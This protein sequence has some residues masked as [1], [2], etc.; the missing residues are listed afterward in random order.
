ML[1]LSFETARKVDAPE[2]QLTEQAK[3][4]TVSLSQQI[5]KRR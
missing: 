3:L 2:Q 4:S 1:I 5:K